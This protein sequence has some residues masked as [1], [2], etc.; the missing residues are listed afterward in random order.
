MRPSCFF[1]FNENENIHNNLIQFSPQWRHS[2]ATH[3]SEPPAIRTR[4]VF[5]PQVE[6]RIRL[7][8]TDKESLICVPI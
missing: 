8:L 3:V 2:G 4:L 6:L 1:F 7:F 5:F